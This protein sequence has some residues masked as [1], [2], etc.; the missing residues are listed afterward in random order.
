MKL[1]Q[2]Q[3]LDSKLND[4]QSIRIVSSYT[5]FLNEEG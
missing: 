2:N 4:F 1:F 3:K 5:P